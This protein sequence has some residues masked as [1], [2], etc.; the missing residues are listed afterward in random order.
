VVVRRVLRIVVIVLDAFLALTAMAGGIGLLTGI[1]GP[2]VEM[3]AGS[4][5]KSYTI[6]GLALL[7]IVGG[8]ALVAAV[9]LLRRHRWGTL[10]SGI[11]AAMIVGFEIVEVLAIGSPPGVARTL[12]I[13]YL[14]LGVV[15]A[16]LAGALWATGRSR[17]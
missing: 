8:S 16:L 15:L 3:L 4:P 1:N 12:Q 9:M 5:F 17:A 10:A 13:F 11:A 2:P 7:L 14:S 6:P